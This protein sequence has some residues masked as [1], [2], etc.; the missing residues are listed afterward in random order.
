MVS[1]PISL[2]LCDGLAVTDASP[3][4]EDRVTANLPLNECVFFFKDF[5]SVKHLSEQAFSG[6]QCLFQLSGRE[7]NVTTN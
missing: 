1:L 5:A 6:D 7:N 2:L 4:R 3:S